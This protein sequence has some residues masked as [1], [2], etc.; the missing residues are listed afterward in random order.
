MAHSLS[1]GISR[2]LESDA[3]MVFLADM[4]HISTQLID[5][6]VNELDKHEI[7]LAES[8]AVPVYNG[9]RGNPVIVGSA[10]FDTLL[11]HTGDTGA[12]FLM[13]QYPDRVLEIPV[14]DSAV[15]LDYDTNEA[16][17]NLTNG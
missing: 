8:I 13:R 15:V 2:V 6:L 14:E 1:Q 17:E 5:L 4:P 11:R 16:L 3:V 9:R 7:K 12:K 10:F